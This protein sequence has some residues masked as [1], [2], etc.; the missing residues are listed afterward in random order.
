MTI[1]LIIEQLINGLIAGSTY[2]LVGSGIALIYGTMRILN[3]AHGEFYMLGGYLVFAL[4][5]LAG[6]PVL[7][8]VPIALALS[9]FLGVGI[10]T[11]VIRPL[12]RKENAAFSVLAVT[13]GLSIVLQNASLLLFGEQFQSIPYYL[14][15]VLAFGEIRLPWQRALIFLVAISSLIAIGTFLKYTRMGWAIRAVS[16]DPDAAAVVGI[17]VERVYAFT[18][19]LAAVLAALAAAMLAP[20][21]GINPWSGLGVLLKGFVVVILG[22]LGSFGG[23]LMGGLMLGVVETIGVQLTSSEWRD[24]IAFGLMIAVISWRPWGLFGKASS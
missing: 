11:I 3:L 5:V 2:A 15:G 16:Q 4:F 14:E 22:G 1:S 24:V 9:F 17:P 6:L 19:G 20:L 12:L 8:S 13:L 23:A 7:I 18:F 10:N 21:Y